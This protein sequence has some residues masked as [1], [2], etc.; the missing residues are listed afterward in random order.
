[1]TGD[2]LSSQ[3]IATCDG[4]VPS[5]SVRTLQQ[6][7]GFREITGRKRKPGYEGLIR[8]ADVNANYTIRSEPSATLRYRRC[9]HNDAV[10][11]NYEANSKCRNR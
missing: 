7:A 10:P 6:G 8:A 3:A 4:S 2:F 11:A 9:V 1:M 5:R